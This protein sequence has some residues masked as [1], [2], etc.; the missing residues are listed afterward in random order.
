VGG[1]GAL[2]PYLYKKNGWLHW[3]AS[4]VGFIGWLS[5]LLIG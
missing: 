3:L 5:L 4:L 1:G 2:L